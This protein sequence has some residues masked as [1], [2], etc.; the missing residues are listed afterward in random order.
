MPTK[1]PRVRAV[2]MY[3]NNSTTINESQVDNEQKWIPAFNQL[4]EDIYYHGVVE[5]L[6]AENPEYY[7]SEFAAFLRLYIDPYF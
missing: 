7:Q 5:Q 2:F 4:M 3:T 1:V 6:L